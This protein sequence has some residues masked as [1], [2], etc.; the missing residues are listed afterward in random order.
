LLEAWCQGQGRGRRIEGVEA[1]F[2]A[3]VVGRQPDWPEWVLNSS[4]RAFSSQC[5][6]CV[7]PPPWLLSAASF[8]SQRERPCHCLHPPASV[9]LVHLGLGQTHYVRLLATQQQ[10]ARTTRRGNKAKGLDAHHANLQIRIATLSLSILQ[11]KER[12]LWV[13]PLWWTATQY[14][15]LLRS[16][17]T[18]GSNVGE[19]IRTLSIARTLG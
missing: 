14:I 8:S 2:G 13:W 16:G 15:G 6:P 3:E 12:V 17:R 19:A 4:V 1:P 10:L 7:A 18:V 11:V 5:L 9:Y